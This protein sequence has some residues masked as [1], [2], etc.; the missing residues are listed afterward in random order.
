MCLLLI[1][2]EWTLVN[3]DEINNNEPLGESVW[4]YW[5]KVCLSVVLFLILLVLFLLLLLITNNQW[6]E[7]SFST[8][9]FARDF[10]KTTYYR[11]WL[12]GK[13][14]GIWRQ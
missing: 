8:G 3:D 11:V 12:I 10:D 2:E 7:E 4:F 13:K 6:F 5:L 9:V 1:E 14:I